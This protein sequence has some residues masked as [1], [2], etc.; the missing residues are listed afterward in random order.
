MHRGA[1]PT[2]IRAQA[3]SYKGMGLAVPTHVGA[4][5]T[6]RMSRPTP[7]ARA[8]ILMRGRAVT[9]RLVG[10][11]EWVALPDLGIERLPAKVDTGARTSALHAVDITA[12]LREDGEWVRFVVP[13][14]VTPARARRVHHARVCD[15]RE[16]KSSIGDA[17]RRFVI[18]TTVQM[19]ERHFHVQ[20]TLTNR[21][22]MEFPML[23]GRNALR[24]G[25]LLVHP[26]RS[27]LQGQ[28][29]A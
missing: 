9:R 21:S 13:E 12:E 14:E 6:P 18:L 22:E 11:R 4:Q 16:V 17:E 5:A 27:F 10:W 15:V 1:A 24:A 2:H 8:Q 26:S 7:D 3:R 19:A 25:R 20:V 28:P 23:I 29:R